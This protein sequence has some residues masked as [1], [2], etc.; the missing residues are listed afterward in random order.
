[1]K[2]KPGKNSFSCSKIY[3]IGQF[4]YISFFFLALSGLSGTKQR[5][6]CIEVEGLQLYMPSITCN[7]KDDLSSMV[8]SLQ[9]KVAYYSLMEYKSNTFNSFEKR[10][11][12]FFSSLF[13]VY[14]SLLPFYVKFEQL[15]VNKWPK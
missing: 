7:N 15:N 11:K 4:Q 5:T 3:R 12:L 1:M 9:F 14:L 6:Q 8:G 2:L 13:T 10:S